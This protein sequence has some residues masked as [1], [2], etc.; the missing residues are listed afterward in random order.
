MDSGNNQSLAPSSR[1]DSE[2]ADDAFSRV[3]DAPLDVRARGDFRAGENRA[4]LEEGAANRV[5]GRLA[6]SGAVLVEE[7]EDGAVEVAFDEVVIV[8]AA[9]KVFRKA[10]SGVRSECGKKG[11]RFAEVPQA[12]GIGEIEAEAG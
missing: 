11:M 12:F 8:P 7:V 9:G 6:D 3:A 5:E 1:A 2:I 10:Q 4:S